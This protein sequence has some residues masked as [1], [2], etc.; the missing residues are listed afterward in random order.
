MPPIDPQ[1]LLKALGPLLTNSGGLKGAQEASRVASL[2]KDASK[3]VTRCVYLNILRATESKD[4]SQKFLEVGGWDILNNWLE[5]ARED[6]N[7]PLLGEILEVYQTLPVTVG[8]LKQNSAA[9]TIKQLSKA[10]KEKIKTLSMALVERWTRIIREQNS[11]AENQEE[12][13]RKQKKNKE[14]NRLREKEME[15]NDKENDKKDGKES[16]KSRNRERDSKEKDSRDKDSKDKDSRDKD[17]RDSKDKDHSHKDRKDKSRYREKDREQDKAK[18]EKSKSSSSSKE[19][20]SS[21]SALSSLKNQ[22]SDLSSNK[23]KDSNSVASKVS[24][25]D[26]VKTSTSASTTTLNNKLPESDFLKDEPRRPK[27][28]K[29]LGTKF[30]STGLFDEEDDDEGETVTRK[31]EKPPVKRVGVDTKMEESSEK[32]PRLHLSMPTL[33]PSNMETAS[34]TP[35]E[36]THG[37]IKLIA[38]K[39]PPAHEIQESSVFIDALQQATYSSGIKRK[40][41]NSSPSVTTAPVTFK[42]S[43]ATSPP[44]A[45]SPPCASSPPPNTQV[46][47]AGPM[48][49]PL[50]SPT[51]VM[52]QKLPSVPSFYR[53]TLEDVPEST[54]VSKK[55]SEPDS[56]SPPPLVKVDSADAEVENETR[57]G[58]ELMDTNEDKSGFL[59][60]QQK[61]ASD[62]KSKKSVSWAREACLEEIF[63]F[64]MD[65]TERENVNRP[66]SFMDMKKAEMLLDRRAMESAKR[67]NN[68]TMVEVL[69]W[70]HPKPIDNVIVLVESGC[71]SAEKHVQMKREQGVL[72]ALFFNK[73]PD[74]P[75]EPDPDTSTDKVETKIIPL[76]D[77]NGSCTEYKHTYNFN[78]PSSLPY[79]PEFGGLPLQN[80]QGPQ[81]NPEMNSLGA[82]S[83]S[84]ANNMSMGN[85]RGHMN[86][87]PPISHILNTLQQQAQETRDPVIQNLQGMLTN[88]LQNTNPQDSGMLM[89][90]ILNALEPFKNQI[91]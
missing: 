63:Y 56:D 65:E 8:L 58:E 82:G 17:S 50:L 16:E 13:K 22:S 47:E 2:M 49:P 60:S 37:R 4:A 7:E 24:S 33:T 79:D 29:M 81:M 40:K 46:S 38:P 28:V 1:Q 23:S 15:K 69:P 88:V 75:I 90:R 64:E 62:K 34:T 55:E 91:P 10:E 53:D 72:C 74:T 41:K 18:R 67:F 85:F 11:A 6:N 59:E 52:A 31:A 78:D 14:K 21:S 80:H 48:S 51:T 77:E 68:D 19:S 89:E 32:K 26:D 43:S 45:S 42:N 3:L 35:P 20:S 36:V 30:R 27:T 39:R 73:V 61:P 44:S 57:A 83:M 5:V 12:D 87:P 84:L 9:K 25:V 70:R 66:K 76:E 71:N 86:I 54:G